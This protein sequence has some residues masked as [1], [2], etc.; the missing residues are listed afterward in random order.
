[1]LDHLDIDDCIHVECPIDWDGIIPIVRDGGKDKI[2]ASFK[3]PS[4]SDFQSIEKMAKG[5]AESDPDVFRKWAFRRCLVDWSL[6]V[7]VERAGD[8][9]S[10][11]C[12]KRILGLHAAIIDFLAINFE[13]K[14]FYLSKDEEE[15]LVKQS[16]M[17]FSP[18]GRGV[19]DACEGI[20]MFCNLGNMWDKFGFTDSSMGDMKFVDYMRLKFIMAKEG[21]FSKTTGRISQASHPTMISGANGRTVPSRARPVQGQ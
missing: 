8:W 5:E 7:P 12:F 15:T 11:A 18:N 6:D 14:C 13:R 20:T 2:E 9:L 19:S 17:L 1:M 3:T 10:G 16:A 21:E 4:L